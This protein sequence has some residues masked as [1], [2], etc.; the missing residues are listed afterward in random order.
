M[1]TVMLLHARS[2]EAPKLLKQGLGSLSLGVRGHSWL[3]ILENG[4]WLLL[5]LKERERTQ[6]APRPCLPL[7]HDSTDS[8]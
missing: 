7:Q 2:T 4:I 6:G 8:R 5:Y 1:G 3:E